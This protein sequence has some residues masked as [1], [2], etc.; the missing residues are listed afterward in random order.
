LK[1]IRS[2]VADKIVQSP[3][4]KLD[5]YWSPLSCLVKE[6]E[7]EDA[8]HV[9]ADHLLLILTAILKPKVINKIS[10]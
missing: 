2:V 8:E 10:E 1:N 9:I 4:N 5:N 7:E 6:Q 3:A